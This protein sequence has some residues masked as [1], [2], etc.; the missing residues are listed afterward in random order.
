M[1]TI[2]RSHFLL[3]AAALAFVP[4]AGAQIMAGQVLA[5]VSDAY[6][7]LKSYQIEATDTYA[8]QFAE[9]QTKLLLAVDEAGKLRLERDDGQNKVIVVSN[10]D[11][12]WT[13]S[14]S[15][16]QYSVL[17]SAASIVQG[18]DDNS[19]DPAAKTEGLLLTRYRALERYAD[20][21]KLDGNQ[22]V[23]LGGQKIACYVVEVQVDKV[24]VKLWVDQERFL[25]LRQDQTD[26]S[27]IFGKLEIKRFSTAGPLES[28]LFE[29]TPPA[30]AREVDVLSQRGSSLVGK[31]ARDFKL[32][33]LDGNEVTL[34]ELRGKVVLIDFWATWC[35]PCREELPSIAK[36][37]TAY[38]DK[39]VVVLGI[40]D[41]DR[42]T[43]KHYL[44]KQGLSLTVLMDSGEKVHGQ[45]G[46]HALPTVVIINREGTVTAQYIG[47]RSEQELRAAL[48]TAGA[49][50]D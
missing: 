20:K 12:T 11:T 32:K 42:G 36:L 33:D 3:W 37:N 21:A 38:G 40:N 43:V 31:P 9:V 6:R 39:D 23:K 24:H 2:S 27:G 46:C 48:Q 16:H 17:R 26:L 5:R 13:Y 25:V 22:N 28:D 49:S 35:P 29:F 47:G 44:E 19:D 18:D 14:P 4:S 10:G 34:S 50:V 30:N 8:A 45:Y 41:E 1:K 7:A 15:V